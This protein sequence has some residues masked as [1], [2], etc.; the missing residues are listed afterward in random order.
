MPDRSAY[1]TKSNT[2]P[3]WT[4]QAITKFPLLPVESQRVWFCKS[5]WNIHAGLILLFHMMAHISSTAFDTKVTCR[6]PCCSVDSSCMSIIQTTAY[7]NYTQIQK[8]DI[9]NCST[10]SWNNLIKKTY[11]SFFIMYKTLWQCIMKIVCCCLTMFRNFQ[12]D[13]S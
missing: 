12:L 2:D 8:F 7:S 6:H 9:Q 1:I 11:S 5:V 4:I 13:E 3:P 10:L